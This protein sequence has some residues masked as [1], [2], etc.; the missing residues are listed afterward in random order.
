MENKG[1][2]DDAGVTNSTV[3]DETQS[4]VHLADLDK[5]ND[6]AINGQEGVSESPVD[7]SSI[8]KPKGTDA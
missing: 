1:F 6:G 3:A 8:P 5:T 7:E 2:V 4:Q